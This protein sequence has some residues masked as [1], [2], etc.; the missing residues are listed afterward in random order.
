[1]GIRAHGYHPL[2][3]SLSLLGCCFQSPISRD[4]GCDASPIYPLWRS[5]FHGSQNIPTMS[6]LALHWSFLPTPDY[7][8]IPGYRVSVLVSAINV[9]F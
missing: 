7:L 9:V 1:M 4:I 2:I 8:S 6:E 5:S 3:P